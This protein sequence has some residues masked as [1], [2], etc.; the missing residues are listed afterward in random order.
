M[1]WKSTDIK[2]D[3]ES[4]QIRKDAKDTGMRYMGYATMHPREGIDGC[5][6]EMR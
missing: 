6:D 2:K 4:E 5:G 1:G 3:Q